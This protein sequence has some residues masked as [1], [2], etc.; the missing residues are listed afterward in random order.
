MY[1]SLSWHHKPIDNKVW[2]FGSKI[3]KLD[4][5]YARTQVSDINNMDKVI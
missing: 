3:L 4:M 5:S 2:I 1:V